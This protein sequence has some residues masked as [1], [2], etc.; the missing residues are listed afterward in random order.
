MLKILLKTNQHKVK[1]LFENLDNFSFIFFLVIREVTAALLSPQFFNYIT[2]SFTEEI[3]TIAQVRIIL[4]DIASCSLMRLDNQSLE[5]LLDLMIMI[6][7]W[8]LFLMSNPDD[9][10]HITLRHLQG[11]GRLFPEQGKMI[12]IDQ[13]NQFFYTHWN[14]LSEE[15]RYVIVRSVKNLHFIDF[16]LIFDLIVE[17]STNFWLHSASESHC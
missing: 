13:S 12:L 4:S 14:E 10:Y 9:L 16:I 1:K 7:K 17:N 5:K 8:Q 11:I 2:T 3:V 6:F 15:N